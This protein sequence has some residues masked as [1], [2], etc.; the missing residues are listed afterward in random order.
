[1]FSRSFFLWVSKSRD[2]LVKV[3]CLYIYIY[4]LFSGP[5]PFIVVGEI[6]RQEPRAAAMGFSI[7]WNWICNFILSLTFRFIQVSIAIIF[8]VVV[9]NKQSG[10]KIPSNYMHAIKFFT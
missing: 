9:K 2:C 3:Y 4:I 10:P 7:A 8:L 6:F 5:I 1:M